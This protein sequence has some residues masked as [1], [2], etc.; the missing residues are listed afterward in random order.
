MTLPAY[1]WCP[2]CAEMVSPMPSGQCVWCDTPTRQRAPAKMGKPAG[3][4]GYLTDEQ[5]RAVHRMYEQGLSLSACA[6]RILP[7]TRYRSLRSCTNSLHDQFVRLGLPRRDRIEATIAASTTHGLAP[8]SGIDPAHRHAMKVARGEILDRPLCAG[9]RERY[10]RK[11]APCQ[12][13]SQS[14]S[15]YCRAH[16]PARRAEV[17]ADLARARAAA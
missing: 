14:S 5:V 12:C 9:V 10:P 8:R 7:R 15:P 1:A 2:A 3:V 6:A 11:G 17:A 16:D 4:H 13:R